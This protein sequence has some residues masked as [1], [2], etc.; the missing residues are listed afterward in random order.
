MT[1]SAAE[2]GGFLTAAGAALVLLVKTC[3][4]H[5]S[6]FGLI[7]SAPPT[8]LTAGASMCPVARAR[9][10]SFVDAPLRAGGPAGP[11]FTTLHAADL[12]GALPVMPG[13]RVGGCLALG[14]AYIA[15]VA[16]FDA[17]GDAAIYVPLSLSLVAYWAILLLSLY[18]YWH[19]VLGEVHKEFKLAFGEHYLRRWCPCLRCCVG[20]TRGTRTSD[21]ERA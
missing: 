3:G 4:C 21:A 20:C 13:L 2:W 8:N 9:F 14:I 15:D 12:A 5:P 7:V 18:W 19:D 10:P 17:G 16:T 11:H 1:W 6:I